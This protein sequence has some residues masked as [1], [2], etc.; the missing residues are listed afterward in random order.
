MLK[1]FMQECRFGDKICY[2]SQTSAIVFINS[3][4]TSACHTAHLPNNKIFAGIIF[5]STWK[6]MKPNGKWY[7]KGCTA[8]KVQ[9]PLHLKIVKKMPTM[10]TKVQ[11]SF[12]GPIFSLRIHVLKITPK[13]T[14][15]SL[16]AETN[17]A[18]LRERANLRHGFFECHILS[19]I[20]IK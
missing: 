18:G 7:N 8:H 1:H 20:L 6:N 4:K 11:V 13:I 3:T 15:V 14:L 19:F 9:I 12:T 16:R 5:T 17:A 2:F 10:T